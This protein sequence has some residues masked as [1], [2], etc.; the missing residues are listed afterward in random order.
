LGWIQP[1]EFLS[2][3]LGGGKTIGPGVLVRQLVQFDLVDGGNPDVSGP[4]DIAPLA[5]AHA[6]PFPKPDRLRLLALPNGWQELLLKQQH[7]G[8]PTPDPGMP[9]SLS[10]APVVWIESLRALVRVLTILASLAAATCD[11]KRL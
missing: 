1:G 4:R 3:L 7:A 9:S 10:C 8:Q 5:G 11:E 2:K 6:S